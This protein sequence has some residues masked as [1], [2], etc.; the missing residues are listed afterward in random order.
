MRLLSWGPSRNPALVAQAYQADQEL[1][2]AIKCVYVATRYRESRT[3]ATR[4]SP[5]ERNCPNGEAS[6]DASDDHVGSRVGASS[7]AGDHF[8]GV[9]DVAG[10]HYI[11]RARSLGSHA[12]LFTRADGLREAGGG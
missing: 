10:W 11:L 2:R 6:A 1:Y 9:V 4:R 12:G 3:L 8:D 5:C 7:G